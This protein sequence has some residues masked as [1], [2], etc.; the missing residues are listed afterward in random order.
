MINNRITSAIY[1]T[2]LTTL[3]FVGILLV[4]GILEG[5]LR[6]ELVIYYTNLSNILCLVV[7]SIVLVDNIKKIQNGEL[8]GHNDKIVKLK[9]ATTMAIMVTGIVYHFL[10]GD[11]K[12]EGFFNLDNIIVHYIVPFMFVLDWILFDKKHSLTLKDPLTWLAIPYIYCGYALIRGPI[13]G[14]EHPIQYA[15]FFIDVNIYGY[16]GVFL[17]VIGLTA[18]FLLVGYLMWFVEKIIKVDGKIKFVHKVDDTE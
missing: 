15:Y 11:P 13:V 6:G 17:W 16:G 18:A 7:I 12:A 2:V 9:A 10:L 3:S 14:P 8:V 4:S 5:T 1:R